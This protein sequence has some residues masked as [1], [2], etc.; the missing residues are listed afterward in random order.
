MCTHATGVLTLSCGASLCSHEDTTFDTYLASYGECPANSSDGNVTV[1]VSNDDDLT[2]TETEVGASSLLFEDLDAYESFFVSV[3]R[4]VLVLLS[5]RWLCA[6]VRRCRPRVEVACRW[7]GVVAASQRARALAR[8][9]RGSVRVHARVRC[10]AEVTMHNPACP[11]CAKCALVH[12][13]D[14]LGC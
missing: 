4:C 1:I 8:V 5:V 7:V 2:C 10:K 6:F 9:P 14:T 12:G 13:A 11:L 3:E